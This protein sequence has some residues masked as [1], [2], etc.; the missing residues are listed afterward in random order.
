[1]KL[2]SRSGIILAGT[3]LMASVSAQALVVIPGVYNTGLGVDGAALADGDGQVDANYFVESTGAHA[4]TYHNS[5]YLQDSPASRIVNASGTEDAPTNTI[6]SFYTTFDLTG[7]N[8][9]SAELSG[10]ALADNVGAVFLNDIQISGYVSGFNSLTSFE[11]NSN[12]VAGVNKLSFMLYNKDG[13]EGFRISDLT[14]SAT[15]GTV[16]EPE[17]WILLTAGFGMIGF[18]TRRRSR[19]IATV[20]A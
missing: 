15:A 5:V 9:A 12:F 14:V 3:L 13:P 6:T 1:M 10:S 16:P 17:T 2:I 18:S 8:V 19:A 7:Y 4:L 20:T 11:A